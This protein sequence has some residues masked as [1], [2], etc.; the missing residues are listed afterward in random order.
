MKYFD[1][2]GAMVPVTLRTLNYCQVNEKDTSINLLNL[3]PETEDRITNSPY[4]YSNR[5]VHN[6]QQSVSP[7]TTA[8]YQEYQTKTGGTLLNL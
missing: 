1:E 8:L 7:S 4:F 5:T 2:N 6:H 3:Q